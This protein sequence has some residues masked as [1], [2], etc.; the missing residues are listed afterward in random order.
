MKN[1]LLTDINAYDALRYLKG[2][3]NEDANFIFIKKD[4]HLLL[5]N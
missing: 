4:Y 3:Y 1:T 5:K 2:N